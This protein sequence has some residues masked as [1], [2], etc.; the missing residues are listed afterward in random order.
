MIGCTASGGGGARHA[1]LAKFQGDKRNAKATLI[2]C[3]G[4]VED[5]GGIEML[6]LSRER[7]GQRFGSAWNSADLPRLGDYRLWVDAKG[8][9]RLK[10]GAPE[11]DEDGS[12]IGG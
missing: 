1:K 2:G 6:D 7:P 12:A 10:K 8:K 5:A 3:H 11:S 9:L 4:A